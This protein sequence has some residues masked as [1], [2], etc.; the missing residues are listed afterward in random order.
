MTKLKTI[1]LKGKEYA[2][3]AERIKQFREDCPNGLI[4]TVPTI[5]ADTIMFTARILKDKAKQT[6]A[7]GTGHSYGKLTGDKAFEKHETIAVGRALAMLGYM[8]SGEVASFE[9]MDDFLEYQGEK[10]EKA[11]LEMG[12]TKTLDELKT[13]FMGLGTLMK[14]PKIIE[15]K[16]E[17]KEELCKL[18][19]SN[20]AQTSGKNTEKVKSPEP[21][22]VISTPSVAVAK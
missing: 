3:V 2:Q 22:L 9:E 12:Q 7:E 18:L 5:N 14:D 16:D 20:N 1:D 17:R 21:S 19:K 11:I 8:A 6:S 10:V 15:A 13:L 4:E